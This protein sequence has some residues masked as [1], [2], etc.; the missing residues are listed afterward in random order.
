MRDSHELFTRLNPVLNDVE[1]FFKRTLSLDDDG[2]SRGP[3]E[4]EVFSKLPA[5]M[6]TEISVA[7]SQNFR[8]GHITGIF[9]DLK[10]G[11]WVSKPASAAAAD[12]VATADK[13]IV[14]RLLALFCDWVAAFGLSVLVRPVALAGVLLQARSVSRP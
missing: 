14:A 9:N 8:S 13:C 11:V 12:M 7:Q 1:A 6:Q 5:A 3:F 10:N 2:V 4:K